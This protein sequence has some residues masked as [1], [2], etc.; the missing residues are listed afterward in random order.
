MKEQDDIQND[1]FFGS[2]Y[3][4]TKWEYN[5]ADFECIL[6]ISEFN[7]AENQPMKRQKNRL[8]SEIN[9]KSAK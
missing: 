4:N 1:T 9:S 5:L 8:N 6:C 7:L 2:T 3:D